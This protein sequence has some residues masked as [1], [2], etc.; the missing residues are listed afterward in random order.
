[1]HEALIHNWNSV[2]KPNDT[3]YHLGDFSLLTIPSRI[4]EILSQLNGRIRLVEGNHD[5]WTK[6][7]PQ[8]KHGKKIEWVKPYFSHKFGSHFIV[9]CHY[10]F[11]TWDKSHHGS[12]CL[13]G[14]CHGSMD[15]ENLN[16]RRMDV[17]VDSIETQYTPIALEDVVKEL[18]SVGTYVNHHRN[19]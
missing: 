5:K 19:N 2:V 12:Y 13:H 16:L 17:G 1:M 18:E 9:M 8:L 4:D 6:K 15:D 7:I 14:H 3:V 11:R 10:P